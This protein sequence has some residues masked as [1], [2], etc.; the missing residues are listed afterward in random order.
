MLIILEVKYLEFDFQ[1]SLSSHEQE[2][3]LQFTGKDYEELSLIC[4]WTLEA[5]LSRSVRRLPWL[6]GALQPA[7]LEPIL[8]L[9]GCLPGEELLLL[10]LPQQVS[11]QP[12]LV[13]GLLLLP[14]PLGLLRPLRRQPLLFQL[15]LIRRL[16]SGD[17]LGWRMHLG[18]SEQEQSGALGL[19]FTH[20]SWHGQKAG[21][22]Y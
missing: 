11:L 20:F 14:Q 16:E 1:F 21:L 3:P 18:N 7:L 2:E 8:P 15:L 5:K 10:V 12:L 9:S 17:W 19:P 22:V 13:Q 4:L 6:L